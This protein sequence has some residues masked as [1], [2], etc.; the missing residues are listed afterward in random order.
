MGP[1]IE[2]YFAVYD[3]SPVTNPEKW[4]KHEAKKD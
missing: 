1:P 4:K 2:F 3:S